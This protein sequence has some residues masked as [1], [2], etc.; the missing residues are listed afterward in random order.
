MAN[1]F[2]KGIKVTSGFD[3]SAKGPLDNRTVVDTIAQRDAH[4]S[5]G[6]AYEGLKVFVT[7]TQKEYVY[8]N[9]GWV[10]SGGITDD[11]LAQLTI[12]Y[13]HSTT[14]HVSKEMVDNLNE[15]IQSLPSLSDINEMV[16]AKAD[17]G[18]NHDDMYYT[19]KEVDEKIVDAVTNGQVDLSNYAT[20]NDLARKSDLGHNHTITDITELSGLLDNKAN[21]DE[22]ATLDA[23]AGKA[24]I[25]HNHDTIYYRKGLVDAKIDALSIHSYA[26][27]EDLTALA[28]LKADKNHTHDY[29]SNIALITESEL[30]EVLLSVFGIALED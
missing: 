25:S 17:A 29:M 13:T 3:L 11:Q 14:E 27:L 1:N 22:V 9:T 18:H 7:A 6:R 30:E 12:A 10:E 19:Q 28:N 15:Q 4:V 16:K 24:D 20:I 26:K 23:I 8:T 5:A 21:K 2:G